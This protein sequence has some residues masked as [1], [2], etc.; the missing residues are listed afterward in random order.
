MIFTRLDENQ[1]RNL[2][3]HWD[4]FKGSVNRHAIHQNPSTAHY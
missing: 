1:S 4:E 3:Y 2:L